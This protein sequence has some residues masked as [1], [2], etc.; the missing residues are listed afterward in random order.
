MI[1]LTKTLNLSTNAESSTDPF[2]NDFYCN[3]GIQKEIMLGTFFFMI[4]KNIYIFIICFDSQTHT[5]HLD[6]AT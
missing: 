5:Q 3:D 6:I 1:R 2:L 4:V